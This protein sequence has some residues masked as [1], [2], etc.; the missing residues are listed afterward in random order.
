MF[1]KSLP[2][3]DAG[4]FV[5]MSDLLPALTAEANALPDNHLMNERNGLT[6]LLRLPLDVV[7]E[8]ADIERQHLLLLL[9]VVWTNHAGRLICGAH[10]L[11]C[12]R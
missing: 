1:A 6:N 10:G 7:A 11:S 8:F 9:A 5:M 2:C 3:L 12:G 4:I